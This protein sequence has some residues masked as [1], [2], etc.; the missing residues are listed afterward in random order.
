MPTTLWRASARLVAVPLVASAVL[1]GPTDVA[2]PNA[3]ASP[4]ARPLAGS[5]VSA[6]VEQKVAP[7]ERRRQLRKDRIW[8]GSVFYGRAR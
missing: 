6:A 8:T 1:L 3:S 7:Q 5:A 4:A 2:T